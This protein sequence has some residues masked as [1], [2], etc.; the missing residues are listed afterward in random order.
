MIG[1]STFPTSV[2]LVVCTST[3]LPGTYILWQLTKNTCIALHVMS[4]VEP[5]AKL[6]NCKQMK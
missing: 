2:H 5:S 4:D 3:I 1:V 6:L